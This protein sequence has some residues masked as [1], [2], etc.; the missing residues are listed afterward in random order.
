[1][2]SSI[3][4]YNRTYRAVELDGFVQAQGWIWILNDFK[5]E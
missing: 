3:A 5:Y 4:I 1:M 2:A